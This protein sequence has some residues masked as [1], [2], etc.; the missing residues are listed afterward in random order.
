M[1]GVN[2]FSSGLTDQNCRGNGAQ[3]S[4]LGQENKDQWVP[5]IPCYDP[6]AGGRL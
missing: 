4:K 1:N 3:G 2:F 6:A 5:D